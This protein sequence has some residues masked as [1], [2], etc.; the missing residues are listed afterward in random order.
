MSD[1]LNT[2]DSAA[3]VI[4]S[5]T[6][7]PVTQIDQASA[8]AISE[9]VRE[10]DAA[11]PET[12]T[13]TP[14]PANPGPALSTPSESVSAA[15]Q[16]EPGSNTDQIRA[17][18]KAEFDSHLL[19]QQNEALQLE[20]KLLRERLDAKP[21]E[22]PL[23][24][25][26]LPSALRTKPLDTLQRLGLNPDSVIR[27]ALAQKLGDKADPALLRAVEDANAQASTDAKISALESQ[28]HRMSQEAARRAY[29]DQVNADGA[30]HIQGL[31][32]KPDLPTVSRVAKSNGARVHAEMMEE[33]VRDAQARVA[34][35]PGAA[36]ITFD[37]AL[38]RVERRWSEYSTLFTGSTPGTASTQ[39]TTQAPLS[40][41]NPAQPKPGAVPKPPD[42]PLP[43]WLQRRANEEDG[44]KAA[45]DEF[46]RAESQLK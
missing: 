27:A 11:A 1:T 40:P 7:W 22:S 34:R 13:P 14:A 8:S 5:S 44:L 15:V 3:P 30:K 45:M 18:I 26:G 39:L 38:K 28:L 31:G 9:I 21:A 16:A 12:E 41:S 24:L 2:N 6:S 29:F 20:L 42:R 37:E 25:A 19:K 23:D 10:F 17:E 46:R 32:D 36:P 33:I 35:E 4:P 43:A